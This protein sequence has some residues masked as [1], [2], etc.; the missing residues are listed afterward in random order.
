MQFFEQ[1][2]Q[3]RGRTTLLITL[4]GLAV[5]LLGGLSG[6]ATHL[7]LAADVEPGEPLTRNHY[8]IVA[9]ATILTFG[10]IL[11]GSAYRLSQLRSG[12][13]KVA[14]TLGGSLVTAQSSDLLERRVVNIVEEM[15]IAA[16]LSV[17]PVYVMQR[18]LG[19]NAFA[20]G[21]SPDD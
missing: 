5:L 2:D 20:A 7:V 15:A 14:E 1:Q 19:I 8:S 16:G 10:I 18:E 12:G 11:L 17:P 21:W 6:T 13:V 9:T 4:F 3:A